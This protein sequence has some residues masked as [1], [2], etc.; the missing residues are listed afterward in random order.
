[1]C[2][3]PVAFRRRSDGVKD[4][5]KTSVNKADGGSPSLN[6]SEFRGAYLFGFW[7]LKRQVRSTLSSNPCSTELSTA[8]SEL[9]AQPVRHLSSGPVDTTS[10]IRQ[11]RTAFAAKRLDRSRFAL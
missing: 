3:A 4:D 2:R 1:T 11:S 7:F 5:G 10:A 8:S 6:V 9:F